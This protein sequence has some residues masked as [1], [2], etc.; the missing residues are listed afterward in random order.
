MSAIIGQ[1]ICKRVNKLPSGIPKFCTYRSSPIR[2]PVWDGIFA[3][4]VVHALI[5]TFIQ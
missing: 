2:N 4:I 3:G 5:N 1:L